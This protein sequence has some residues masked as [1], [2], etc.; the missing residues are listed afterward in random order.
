[1]SFNQKCL[2]DNWGYSLFLETALSICSLFLETALSIC[3]LFL[4]TALSIY[5][6]M[7]TKLASLFV[8]KYICLFQTF[9]PGNSIMAASR[10]G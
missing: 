1:M 8:D 2:L 3:S 5:I 10:R 7:V 9:P 4:E 6:K